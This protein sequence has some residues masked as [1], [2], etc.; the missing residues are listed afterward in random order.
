MAASHHGLKHTRELREDGQSTGKRPSFRFNGDDKMLILRKL[1][2]VANVNY[3]VVK[4]A[5]NMLTV[6]LQAAEDAKDEGDRVTFWSVNPGHCKTGFNGF[7]GLKDPLDGAE[8]VI[9][10]MESE[11]G[12]VAGGTF[13][14]L[15]QGEFRPIPW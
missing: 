6:H 14:E 1:P 13:W 2:P 12:A 15:E 10:L 3:C 4:A 11:K 7:R 5:L 8:V 9:R